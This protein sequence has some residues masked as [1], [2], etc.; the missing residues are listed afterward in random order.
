MGEP[1][2]TA[3]PEQLRD[4]AVALRHRPFASIEPGGVYWLVEAI[5]SLVDE[6][7]ALRGEVPHQECIKEALRRRTVDPRERTLALVDKVKWHE[8]RIT[9]QHQDLGRLRAERDALRE[10]L[11]AVE[12]GME[13]VGWVT[14]DGLLYSESQHQSNGRKEEREPV[15]RL[16]DAARAALSVPKASDV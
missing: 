9:M 1:L 12:G 4:S 6:N 8:D 7:T 14:A 3:D 13:Q 11:K 5:I 16:S 15:Y 10:R 2:V